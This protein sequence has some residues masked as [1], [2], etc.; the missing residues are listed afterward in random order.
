VCYIL[1]FHQWALWQRS[2]FSMSGA[3]VTCD[4]WT[5][6]NCTH[7]RNYTILRLFIWEFILDNNILYIGSCLSYIYMLCTHVDKMWSRYTMYSSMYNNNLY[8][9]YKCSQYASQ[10]IK[11]EHAIQIIFVR[12]VTQSKAWLYMS[13]GV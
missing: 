12:H 13:H 2:Y 9:K 8:F 4:W 1:T 6:R 3:L 5:I 7:S 10:Y 11:Y